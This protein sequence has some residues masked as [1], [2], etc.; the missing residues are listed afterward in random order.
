MGG[1]APNYPHVATLSRA[2]PSSRSSALPRNLAP[3]LNVKLVVMGTHSTVMVMALFNF[4]NAS[5]MA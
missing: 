3:G 4:Y 5:L 1:R 2:S